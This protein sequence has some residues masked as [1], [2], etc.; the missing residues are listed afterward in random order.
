MT[1]FYIVILA[2]IVMPLVTACESKTL[3][4]ENADLKKQIEALK[5]SN[6]KLEAQ[7]KDLTAKVEA[8]TQKSTKSK[9]MVEKAKPAVKAPTNMIGGT[10]VTL[11]PAMIRGPENALVQI[12]EFSSYQ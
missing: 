5:G 3:K 8:I 10:P 11:N 1:K 4:Q 9:K 12:Y 6:A 7:V 2:F